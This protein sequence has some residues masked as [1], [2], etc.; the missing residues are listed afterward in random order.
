[1]L[2]YK[3][4]TRCAGAFALASAT[5]MLPLSNG[6]AHAADTYKI[7]VAN[8]MAPSHDTSKAVDYFAKL[9]KE[10]SDGSIKMQH[11]PGGQLG[12]D[13]ETF[14]AAQQGLIQIAS[15]SSANLVTI[16]RAFEVL[17]LPFIFGDLDQVHKALQS[18][19]VRER[20]N[21][22][23]AKVGLRWLF[24]FDY[25]FRDINTTSREVAQPK[26]VKGLKL[27]AS[28]SPLE[29]AG[30]ESFGAAA[31]TVDWP[32]V[33]N[34]LRF[35]I[36]DGEA[37]PFGTL[38][39]AKHQEVLRQTLDVNWQ[40]YGFVGLISI[41]QW[42]KYPDSVKKVLEDAA[43]EAETYHRKIWAEEDKKA[44]AAYIKAGGK[45][46]TLTPEQRQAWVKLGK[47]TWANANVPQDL[48]DLVHKTATE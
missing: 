13:N 21:A 37:Q 7:K 16:T 23:L 34:A 2:T 38:V 8:V 39:S 20:I 27:R 6:T 25:G 42:N 36:V 10:K 46:T 47:S 48:I 41:D 14:G 29:I 32:E 22:E 3:Y 35:K 33:Y 44:E 9:V 5:F 43:R 31:V 30:L 19:A 12:S 26:D 40:Y 11:F 17:H 28:R 15:G 4:F 45:V 24:T 18:P 1:M